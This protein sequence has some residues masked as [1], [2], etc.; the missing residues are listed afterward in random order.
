MAE[1]KHR[2]VEIRRDV[3]GKDNPTIDVA[4][5][6]FRAETARL[7][8]VVYMCMYFYVCVFVCSATK[9]NECVCLCDAALA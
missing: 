3:G 1:T 8:Q 4:S 6:M 9:V 2:T 7:D 5:I